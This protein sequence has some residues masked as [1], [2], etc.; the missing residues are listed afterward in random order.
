MPQKKS[1]PKQKITAPA[2]KQKFD[3][4]S[5]GTII[6]TAP[7]AS[8]LYVNKKIQEKTG[9]S[10]GEVIGKKPG[11]LWGGNMPKEFYQNMWQTI[12]RQKQPFIGW[13]KNKKK[14]GT[15]YS[16]L[17]HIA[18]ILNKAGE[19]KFFIEIDISNALDL[20]KSPNF[21]HEFISQF[22]KQKTGDNAIGFFLHLFSLSSPLGTDDFP[23]AQTQKTDSL[24][25][26]FLQKILVE[27]TQTK[28]HDRL[29]DSELIHSAQLNSLRF[30]KL[31]QKYYV[32]IK[33]YFFKR[34]NPAFV[35]D[36]AQETF[37][38][39]FKYLPRFTVSNASYLTYLLRIAHN[40]LAS[41]YR[42]AAHAPPIQDLDL[43]E[44]I[45]AAPIDEAKIWDIE[46]L[47][48]AIHTMSDIEQK[49]LILKYQQDKLVKD[50]AL[51]VGKS[52]NAVKLILSRARKKLRR[53]LVVSK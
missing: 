6:I 31:Y 47:W 22:E 44:N 28:Y 3:D 29:E 39:A 21:D 17:L 1:K 13:V 51:A 46:K 7:D 9:F 5:A 26:Q 36:L 38:Q 18:P 53:A 20:S 37:L 27:P 25:E 23:G 2:L 8:V 30:D 35:E 41:H 4:T 11:Q 33:Q 49:I 48:N 50:I 14:D 45:P 12:G 24:L 16:D 40:V 32:H 34:A 19:I 15:M 43:A 42:S 52:E 10:P